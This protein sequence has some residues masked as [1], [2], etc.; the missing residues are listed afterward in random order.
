M[1]R[2]IFRDSGFKNWDFSL[3]K[4]WKFTERFSAQFRA[5]FFN[6]LNHP[7]FANPY[8]AR[9][10]YDNNDPSGGLGF[11]CG[12]ITPDAAA[13]NFVLGSGG[14]RDIQF[15]LKLLF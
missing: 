7:N 4:N 1:G 14:A 11:G 15:G 5:E 12:C 3:L 10:G 2:N 9:A 6:I 8:G 13:T